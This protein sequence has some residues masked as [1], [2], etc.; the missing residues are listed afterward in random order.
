MANASKPDRKMV[1]LT[2]ARARILPQ[3]QPNGE[4]VV[5]KPVPWANP[6]LMLLGIFAYYSIMLFFAHWRLQ[7][8]PAVQPASAPPHLFSEERAA[9]HV[10][11][12]AGGLPDRQISMPQ[13]Q[14]AHD[15][16]VRQGRLLQQLAEAREARDVEVKVYRE[17]NVSGSVAMDFTGL[18]FTNA[19][20]G[21]TNVV[22]TITPLLGSSSS[23]NT[24]AEEKQ[25]PQ[26]GDTRHGSTGDSSSSG[27]SSSNGGHAAAEDASST[28]TAAAAA[29][30]SSSPKD[31]GSR[32]QQPRG[33]LIAA[34]HDSA[35]ASP[36]ASD[37]ASM[38]GVML[39]AARALLSGPASLLPAAPLVLLFDGG[40]ENLCQGAHGFMS[41]S[42]HARN[43]GAFVNLEAM[44]GG[45]LPLLFQH[46]GA[47]TL[48]AWARG[49][50]HARGSRIAQDLFDTGVIP[51]DT[52]YRMFSARH[53]GSLPGLDIAFTRDSLAYHTR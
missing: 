31:S 11:A 40:E 48:A 46:T 12:L 27:S 41:S 19:Y 49:A 35:V 21:L 50:R 51:G 24:P 34:H 36:G 2:A 30:T 6:R 37:D 18:P 14:Q 29:A 4:R 26:G 3:Q 7:W 25:D 13:L 5:A 43:L 52:D 32:P 23:S 20:R 53:F 17:D 28:A 47:W 9:A 38:V 42:P 22:I 33:L 10:A 44:G 16:I 45:G 1:A 39:E 15:Y 8:T